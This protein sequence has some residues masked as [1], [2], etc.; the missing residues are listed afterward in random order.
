MCRLPFPKGAAFLRF[1][2]KEG[3]HGT[4]GAARPGSWFFWLLDAV[5]KRSF[6]YGGILLQLAFDL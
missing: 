2:E 1:S 4:V 6:A 5:M 3:G